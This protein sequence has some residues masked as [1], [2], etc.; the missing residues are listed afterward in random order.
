[1]A[2]ISH[3]VITAS[4]TDGTS[5]TTSSFTP[6]ADRLLVVFVVASDTVAVGA[7]SDSVDGAMTLVGSTTKNSGAD[8]IYCFVGAALTAS[9]ARTITFTCTGDAAS[10]AVIE[11]AE[12]AGISR[13][14]SAAI[15]QFA[16]Q[17][18][19]AGGGH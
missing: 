15:R 5:F 18:N 13:V 3:R 2:T 16:V 17:A 9:T 8:T 7:C 19:Q 12:V 4:T 6:S 11:V 10:G 14:S 1:M